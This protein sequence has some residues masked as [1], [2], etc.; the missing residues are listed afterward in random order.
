MVLETEGLCS[1]TGLRCYSRVVV[2]ERRS[3]LAGARVLLVEDDD[4]VRNTFALILRHEGLQVLDVAD[5]ITA[6]ERL[7]DQ[8]FDV[9]LCDISIPGVSGLE[10]LESVRS[11]PALVQLQFVLL[12]ARADRSDVRAGM[13]RGADDYL[14]KPVDAEELLDALAARLRRARQLVVQHDPS[15]G[16][17]DLDAFIRW[18]GGEQDAGQR[19]VVAAVVIDRYG[20]LVSA[21][22]VN[23]ERELE[24]EIGRRLQRLATGPVAR[25]A[26][27]QHILCAEMES[28][29][30]MTAVSRLLGAFAE[31]VPAGESDLE[32][33]IS[34]GLAVSPEDGSPEELVYRARTAAVHA[35]A[36]SGCSFLR[37]A[38]SMEVEA[39]A[40]LRL[41]TA[42]R[43]ALQQGSL[44]LLYQ[45]L[46]DAATGRIVSVEALARWRHPQ[47]G[48]IA[49]AEFLPAAR[50][51]GL[52]QVLEE[53]S[54][55]TACRD[56]A[57]WRSAF[58]C[59][60][61]VSVNLSAAHLESPTLRRLL[62][63]TVRE[64][65]LEPEAVT[66]ELLEN[67]VVDEEGNVAAVLAS[68][69]A[70]GFLVAIDDFGTG[71]SS[72]SYLQRLSVD[73]VKID[74][75][76]VT[77]ERT[78]DA[79]GRPLLEGIVDLAHRIGTVVCAEG[80]ETI[81]ELNKVQRAGC[82]LVQGYLFSRALSLP[83]LYEHLAS[84]VMSPRV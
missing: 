33:T 13:A 57:A 46:V 55:R 50:G 48:A 2:D 83:E 5:G 24:R 17:V 25:L 3:D 19:G 60:V 4:D 21:L 75:S 23:G 15:A 80:V 54:L 35:Q 70:A 8:R 18:L 78:D 16:V 26:P 27:E 29:S 28:G 1:G 30:Q 9:I 39:A 47:R 73:E 43:E 76:F 31:P 20:E 74:R 52:E 32:C 38:P 51:A 40:R 53:W 71:Y 37:Y 72:L 64:S 41:E 69:R 58:G 66:L 6:R 7:R 77:G 42:L 34:L 61:G 62:E 79:G 12:T 56:C 49:P 10:L 11:D 81:D 63:E 14:T 45:P 44:Y 22:G 84:G 36:G 65:E 82:D 67:S 59:D 68:V